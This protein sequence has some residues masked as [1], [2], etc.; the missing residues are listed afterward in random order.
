LLE[1]SGDKLNEMAD[2]VLPY[3]NDQEAVA[4]YLEKVV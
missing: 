1:H 2:I 3:T 4:K